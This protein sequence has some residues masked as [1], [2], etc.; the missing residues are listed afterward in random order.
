MEQSDF[1]DTSDAKKQVREKTQNVLICEKSEYYILWNLYLKEKM[2]IHSYHLDKE[3]SIFANKDL[4]LSCEKKSKDLKN[5][6]SKIGE[7]LIN[8]Y[9]AIFPF[10]R[11][12]NSN[13]EII[14]A[15]TNLVKSIQSLFPWFIK[16]SESYE[17]NNIRG[18]HNG[19][20]IE[21]Q[22]LAD[23]LC[24]L[25]CYIDVCSFQYDAMHVFCFL[26][27]D[28]IN[29]CFSTKSQIYYF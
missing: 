4:A 27:E 5:F 20:L 22:S 15:I 24:V 17:I 14:I 29:W 1:M 26:F 13:E 16:K 28:D 19:H 2:A 11:T 25:K 21:N 12:M 9:D 3:Y 18:S 23:V 10:A 6:L 8:V 7:I